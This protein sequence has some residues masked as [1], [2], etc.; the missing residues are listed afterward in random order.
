MVSVD[1]QWGVQTVTLNSNFTV[2]A[3]YERFIVVKG[4]RKAI[5]VASVVIPQSALL[6][7]QVVVDGQT[8]Q[9]DAMIREAIFEFLP[10]SEEV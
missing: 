6:T 3:V 4:E 8:K 7:K 10:L 9:L 2:T 5:D 1:L